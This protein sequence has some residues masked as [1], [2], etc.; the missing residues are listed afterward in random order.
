MLQFK[1]NTYNK[2]QAIGYIRQSDEREDKEAISE[3]T[4]RMKIQQ[5]CDLN[6]LELVEVFKDIDY[7]G[8]RISYLKRPGL[9]EAFEFIKNHPKVRK[10]VAFNLSRITRR[11]KEFTLIQETLQSHDIDICSTAE[12][13]DFGSPTGRLVASI[14]V[15][16]NEYYSDNLSA[17]TSD[18]KLTNAERGRWNGGPAPFGL[19]K[20]DG[21]FVSDGDKG[22][23]VKH[24]FK[25]AYQG[26][27]PYKISK[28]ANN[29]GIKTETGV[30]W[31]PRRMRY[32]LT[33]STYAGMQ[34][35]DGK[36][37]ELKGFDRLVSWDEFLYI[38]STLFGKEKAWRGKDRQLLTSVLRCST[39]GKKMYSRRSGTAKKRR[40]VCCQ[41]N[42]SGGSSCPNIDLT[43][44][45]NAVIELVAEFTRTRYG[46]KSLKGELSSDSNSSL[47]SGLRLELDQIDRAKQKLFDDYYIN[48]R[49]KEKDFEVAMKR[50]EEKQKEISK[51]LERIPMPNKK[52]GDYDSLLKELGL[53][54]AS[55][56]SD[57]IRK[58]I[59]LAIDEIIPG[60]VATVKFKWGEIFT[61]PAKEKK[62]H[63]CDIYFY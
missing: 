24:F 2:I 30:E 15:D 20:H 50:F 56:P 53:A 41:K 3:D 16:F 51:Q 32:L 13:L 40:Y 7:S 54:I 43:S 33:N 23:Y 58:I 39:C 8:F 5:Y 31:T 1:E 60:E 11:K 57:E 62:R 28:W 55:L 18:N 36:Y 47:I 61:I 37:Y 4:Q 29:N 52:F 59:E 63:V 45:D 25:L 14:L 44:L 42:E 6:N 10:F 21:V 46:E 34:R 12:Q 19:V 35:W 26:N 49:I 48:Q 27:G 22:E 38:Q 17:V 9:M